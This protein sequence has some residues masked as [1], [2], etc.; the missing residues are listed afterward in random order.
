[1]EKVVICTV[2]PIGCN[3]TVREEND[4]LVITGNQC[5]RGITYA[6]NEYLHPVRILT[7]TVKVHGGDQV[8]VP[9]RS[10]EPLPKELLFSAMDLIRDLT[11]DAPIHRG[12]VL[13][14]NI[15]DTGIDIVATGEIKC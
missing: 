13:I 9:V 2:C 4:E 5:K 15:L 1:M 3:I 6:T 14:N 11:V 10:A 12:D 8:L 7:T